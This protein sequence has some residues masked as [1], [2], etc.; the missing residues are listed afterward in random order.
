MTQQQNT[1][2]FSKDEHSYVLKTY[3]SNN[4]NIQKVILQLK[5]DTRFHGL[6]SMNSHEYYRNVYNAVL[7]ERVIKE[8]H[9]LMA[10][11][12]TADDEGIR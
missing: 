12:Y 3:R 8:L 5:N 10:E 6:L 4:F 7:E 9:I 1:Y 11:G 2:T